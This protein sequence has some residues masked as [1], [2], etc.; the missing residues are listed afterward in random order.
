[1]KKYL[2]AVLLTICQWTIG[3]ENNSF[4]NNQLSVDF[5]SFRNRYLY[6]MT[7]IQYN[8]AQLKKTNL[9]I[10]VR[11]RSYGTLFFYSKSS[12]DFSPLIEYYFTKTLKP[13]YFSAGIGFDTRIRMINDDRSNAVTSVEPI[14]STTLH[15]NLKK[16][17]FNSALWTRIYSNG[18]SFLIMPEVSYQINKSLSI[19]VRYELSYLTIYNGSTHEWR[20][21]NFLGTHI[22]F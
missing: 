22:Y 2:L 8:S 14:I 11:L 10:S 15:G 4:T 20:H 9:K 5:G 18:I 19:F 13:L 6:P 3:Q 16:L 7:D 17:S 21:D 1:M 12:Y